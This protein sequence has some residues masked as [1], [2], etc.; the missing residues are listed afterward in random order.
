MG[1]TK[2]RLRWGI[3]GSN[4]NLSWG[5]CGVW[6]IPSLCVSLC[7]SDHST[8]RILMW[9]FS[10]YWLLYP[11]GTLTWWWYWLILLFVLAYWICS[12]HDYPAYFDMYVHI[13]VYLVALVLTLFLVYY[14]DHLWACHHCCIHLDC[15]VLVWLVCGHVWYTC[16][17]LDCLLHDCSS[18]VWLHV[19]CLC[20]LYIYPLTSNPLVSIIPFFFSSY[21][22]KC[23]ALCVLVSMTELV[24]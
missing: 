13:V 23:K 9:W 10:S 17:L 1:S 11:F 2:W 6:W 8:L 14:L 21:I 4:L 12:C 19:V 16:T 7:L 22:C 24:G 5:K 3:R 15:H 18:S 20:G